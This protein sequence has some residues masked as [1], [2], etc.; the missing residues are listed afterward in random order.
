MS[1]LP[2]GEAIVPRS[3]APTAPGLAVRLAIAVTAAVAVG[4][5]TLALF[6]RK[7]EHIADFDHVLYGAR[8]LLRGDNPYLAVG[9]GRELDV[10]FPL[11]YPA[12]ALILAAPLTLLSVLWARIVF[13]ALA[14]GTLAYGLTRDGYH[15]LPA[16]ASGAFLSACLLVQWSPLLSA[17]WFLPPLAALLIVKPNLGLAMAG[18]WP[19]R[20]TL[21]WTSLGGI[22][23]LA[24]S[25]AV[26]PTWLAEWLDV[27]RHA[28]H[29]RPFMFYRGGALLLLALLRWRRPEG[30]L[31]ALLAVIPQTPG[32]YDTLL[33]F[34]IPATLNEAC[35]LALLSHGARWV[36]LPTATY[37]VFQD[38]AD[39]TA[40]VSIV[41]V[42]LP[43]LIMLLRRPNEGTLPPR[44]E[45]LARRL[46]RF[47]RGHGAAPADAR[48]G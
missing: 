15:R 37:P 19:S 13:I 6:L 8:V 4:G 16:L 24:A 7:P 45:R 30:R 43:A 28:E 31:V 25:F 9:P 42:Y 26:R 40:R 29:K 2:V 36:L 27:I 20:R 35:L 39:E 21:V 48:Y 32:L 10:P 11:Y 23:L 3:R 34:A 22:A 47:L 14:T 18:A 17:A 41:L 44:V 38:V 5:F 12:P 46:P 33:L 1:E